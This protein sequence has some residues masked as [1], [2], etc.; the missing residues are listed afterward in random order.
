MNEVEKELVNMLAIHGNTQI[1]D[2]FRKLG[3]N[4]V[5]SVVYGVMENK[6]KAEKYDTLG[7]IIKQV[8]NLLNENES[9]KEQNAQL[10][11]IHNADMA[12]IEEFEKRN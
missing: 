7:D 11:Q 1:Y 9:L 12:I 6:E 3:F 5:H 2:V 8:N 10:Q 4:D